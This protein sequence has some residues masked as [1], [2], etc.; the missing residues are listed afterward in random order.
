MNTT[1]SEAPGSVAKSGTTITSITTQ[2]TSPTSPTSTSSCSAPVFVD[3]TYE[4]DIA[5]FGGASYT[6]GREA[7]STYGEK[8]AGVLPYTSS[9]NFLPKVKSYE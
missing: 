7:N 5:R 8:L 2:T 3:A 1:I 9:Q 4:G 6:Y